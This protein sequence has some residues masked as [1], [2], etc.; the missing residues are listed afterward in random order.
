MTSHYFVGIPID[1]SVIPFLSN[2]QETLQQHMDYK[3]WTHPE[4][5]HITLKFLGPSSAEQLQSFVTRLDECD[6]PE[7][8]SLTIGPGGYFGNP[9][10]PRVFHVNVNLVPALKKIHQLVEEAG[11]HAGFAL[12]DRRYTPHI[13]LAKKWKGGQSPLIKEADLFAEKVE[14]KVDRFCIF[15]IHPQQTPKYH[16]TAVYNLR[17][18]PINGTAN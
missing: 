12:E 13:T 7:A 5:F 2:W 10:K 4:D 9:E 15:Q 11:K 14:L 1:P 6:W 18:G 8:F 16:K 3:V 17:K